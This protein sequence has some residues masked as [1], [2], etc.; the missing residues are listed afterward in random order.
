MKIVSPKIKNYVEY[1]II[2]SM[3]DNDYLKNLLNF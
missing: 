1:S 2:D 3:N